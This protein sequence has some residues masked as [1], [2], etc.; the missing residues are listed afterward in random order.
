[1]EYQNNIFTRIINGSVNSNIIA[2]NENAIAIH[3]IAPQ[4]KIHVLLIPK[5]N[6][7]NYYDFISRGSQKE[8]IDFNNLYK[9]II[10]MFNI[11]ESHNIKVNNGT[12]HGQEV[13]HTHMHILSNI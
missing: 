1:M 11:Q 10:D 5:N 13:F 4:A 6:Y 2:S 3:D 8:Q 9:Q 12:S 7:V